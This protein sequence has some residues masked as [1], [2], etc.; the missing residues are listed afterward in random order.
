[1]RRF[2]SRHQP[3]TCQFCPLKAGLGAMVAVGLCAWMGEEMG[4]AL[5]AAPLLT[6]A[7]M[8][9]S[10]H[11]NPM[12]QPANVVGGHVLSAGIALGM[13][14]FMP[15]TWWAVA[16]AVA[17]V[18]VLMTLCRLT[19]PPAAANALVVMLE[20]GLDYLVFPVLFGALAVVATAVIVHRLVPPRGHYPLPAPAAP[21]CAPAE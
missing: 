7:V 6:S 15:Q 18:M 14:E 19:H 21:T 5:L 9:F 11:E 12:A 13:A 3:A 4:G 20:P 2:V 1:M 16:V 10:A 8:V 17:V